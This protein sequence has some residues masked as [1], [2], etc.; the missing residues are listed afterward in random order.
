MFD[1]DAYWDRR[2]NR[3]RGQGEDA[4]TK[5]RH[6]TRAVFN[7]AASRMKS[8]VKFFDPDHPEGIVHTRKKAPHHTPNA[9][10]KR[11]MDHTPDLKRDTLTKHKSRNR[12]NNARNRAKGV[13]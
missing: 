10:K 12:R 13:E 6:K 2:R 11:Y 1:K 3:K 9:S 7:R 8:R 5:T 4:G